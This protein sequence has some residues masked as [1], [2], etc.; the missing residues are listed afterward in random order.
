MKKY[1][2][3][4]DRDKTRKMHGR[5]LLTRALAIPSR[6][7]I[8]LPRR[9]AFGS[10]KF[11]VFVRLVHKCFADQ[12]SQEQSIRVG[13][14]C[15]FWAERCVII[16]CG[17]PL[18]H[19]AYKVCVKSCLTSPIELFYFWLPPP[20]HHHRRV[21][22]RRQTTIE[23]YRTGKPFY[24]NDVDDDD[25]DDA[26]AVRGRTKWTRRSRRRRYSS[27]MVFRSLA[28]KLLLLFT[29]RM[30]SSI[31]YNNIA[32]LG[33]ATCHVSRGSKIRHRQPVMKRF[34]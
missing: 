33:G 14:M 12:S 9:T 18:T 11:R 32:R 20:N 2:T 31:L 1:T 5:R 22:M 17:T 21:H 6:E 23:Y 8:V 30:A 3:L 4:F 15:T 34:L 7:T 24:D 27:S 28:T 16:A 13:G 19:N 29:R 10:W 26:V 25:D